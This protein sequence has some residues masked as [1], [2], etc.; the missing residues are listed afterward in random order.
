[1]GKKYW[2]I[3]ETMEKEIVSISSDYPDM[4]QIQSGKCYSNLGF[5][6]CYKRCKKL[7]NELGTL[8]F[9]AKRGTLKL[10]EQYLELTKMA[11]KKNKE[12]GWESKS[13]L[14]PEFIGLEG[15]RVEVEYSWGKER[16]YIGK[17]TGWIP[18]HLEIKRKDS[19]GGREVLSGFKSFKLL[20]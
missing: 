9:L 6:V 20:T 19:H 17:S 18:C 3:R 11:R 10:Y 4:Y 1:M 5:D 14:I 7:R 8:M 12:T 16:F 2:L 15:K 13:E